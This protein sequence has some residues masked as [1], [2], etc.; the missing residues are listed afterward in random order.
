MKKFFVFIFVIFLGSL[1]LF[2]QTISN[3]KIIDSVLTEFSNKLIVKCEE[4]KISRISLR[5]GDS[6]VNY[7]SDFINSKIIESKINIYEPNS[8]ENSTNFLKLKI[9]IPKFEI[10]Y[11]YLEGENLKRS[12]LSKFEVFKVDESGEISL[13]LQEE[14]A[15]SDTI[16]NSDIQIIEDPLY[17]F[18]KGKIPKKKSNFFDEIL[19]PA[20]IVSA[21]LI[22]VILFFSVRS[23]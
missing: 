10:N 2:S 11:N 6:P 9:S 20:I 22:S 8:L 15:Y 18:T 23:K 4:A 3:K 7:F 1:S 12:L 21:S 14:N 16:I 19:E 5:Y 13:L 17:P